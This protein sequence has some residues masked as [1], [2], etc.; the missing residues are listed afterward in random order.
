VRRGLRKEHAREVALVS[1]DINFWLKAL[2]LAAW[3]G[4]GALNVYLYLQSKSDKRFEEYDRALADYDTQQAGFDRRLV[5]LETEFESAPDHADLQRIQDALTELSG[6]VSTVKERSM[7]SLQSL[8]R[9]EAHL[10]ERSK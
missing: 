4:S 8:R 2:Q 5:K 6:D 1:F 7:N 3:L 10:L 9:I